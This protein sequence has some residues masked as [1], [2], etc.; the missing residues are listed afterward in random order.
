MTDYL[1]AMG[2]DTET[3]VPTRETLLDLGLEGERY[4]YAPARERGGKRSRTG[5]PRVMGGIL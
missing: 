2:W 5:R 4:G 1:K 3:G